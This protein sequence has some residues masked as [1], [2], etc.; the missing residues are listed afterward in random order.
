MNRKTGKSCTITSAPWI[1]GYSRLWREKESWRFFR[2][3]KHSEPLKQ[4]ELGMKNIFRTASVE[5]VKNIFVLTVSVCRKIEMHNIIIQL[6]CF[7]RLKVELQGI[8]RQGAKTITRP[9]G[10]R[11]CARCQRLLGKF[12]DCGSVCCGCSH[13]ICKRCRVVCSAQ[14]W[15]CTLCHAYR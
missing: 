5:Q 13:R 2:E 1:S 15:K 3:T 12:W 8:C 11:S 7:R 10:Q 4:T 9:Y 14:E 6:I